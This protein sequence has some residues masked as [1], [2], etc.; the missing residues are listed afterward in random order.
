MTT[1]NLSVITSINN[2]SNFS[3]AHSEHNLIDPINQQFYNPIPS[4]YISSKG[5]PIQLYF[6]I[7]QLN[8][9]EFTRNIRKYVPVDF[10]YTVFIKVRYN[11]D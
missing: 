11:L 1:R 8:S 7:F 2:R 5:L 4:T 6:T 3:I 9:S 10:V